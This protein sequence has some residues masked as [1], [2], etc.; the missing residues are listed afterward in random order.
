MAQG[1]VRKKR[2]TAWTTLALGACAEPAATPAPPPAAPA[3]PPVITAPPPP[4]PAPPRDSC[5]A[6]PLQ[7]LVG[8]PRTEIPVPVDPSRR[9]VVCSTCTI[10]QDFVTSRLTITYD[11]STGLVKSVRCG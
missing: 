11:S 4:R 9:R 1:S 10:T 6:A 3:P 2:V 7:Y 8:R 5:G